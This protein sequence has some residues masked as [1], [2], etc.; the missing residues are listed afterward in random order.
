[1]LRMNEIEIY[2]DASPLVTS[3]FP[4]LESENRDLI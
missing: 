2:Q 4:I 1:M 3:A